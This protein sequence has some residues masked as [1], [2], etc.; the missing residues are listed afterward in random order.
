MSSSMLYSDEVY[1][2]SPLDAVRSSPSSKMPYVPSKP[3]KGSVLASSEDSE[4]VRIEAIVVKEELH[5]NVMVMVM[6]R[7]KERS[8]SMIKRCVVEVVLSRGAVSVIRGGS[9]VIGVL[10][11]QTVCA[12]IV[13]APF[14]VHG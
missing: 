11:R 10:R 13:Q 7:C 4:V 1:K 8:D 5:E 9:S 3:V 12:S 2:G 6:C 14:A